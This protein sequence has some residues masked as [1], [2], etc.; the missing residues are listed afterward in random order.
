MKMSKLG[1]FSEFLLFPPFLL[2]AMLSAFRSPVQLQPIIWVIGY[3]SGLIGWT[4]IEYLLHRLLFH[5]VPILSQIHAR[6]HE[7][8]Q[9]LIGTPAWASLLL[10]SVA[11]GGP[12][13]EI[14]G[15]DRATAVTA[16]IFTGYLWYVFVHYAIHHWRLRRNS[17]FNR[18]RVRHALHHHHSQNSNFGVTTGVWDYI[19]G[20]AFERIM[21]DRSSL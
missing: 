9:E 17:Y 15:F 6:H 2:L 16:G 20:T 14:L 7:S 18:A 13:W 21:Q 4:L 10:G 5:H 1:Y 11:I 8:P 19:F 12:S 3:G